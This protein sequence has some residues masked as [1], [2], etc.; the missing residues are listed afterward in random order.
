MALVLCTGV[1][2]NLL[3]TRRLLLETAGHEVVTVTS[4]TELLAACEK[5]SFEVAVVG[6]AIDSRTKRRLA[7]L[8]RQH[9]RDVRILELYHAHLG[10]ILDDADGWMLIPAEVPRELVD[11]VTELA[12]TEGRRGKN[13]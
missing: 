8:I 3:K 5:H 7:T 4:E 6:Q 1:H 10:R 13:A 9:C 11:R 2:Q 12:K